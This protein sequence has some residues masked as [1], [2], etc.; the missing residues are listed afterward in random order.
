MVKI[1]IKDHLKLNVP[2]VFF[3]LEGVAS[4]IKLNTLSRHIIFFSELGI[5]IHSARTFIF[6]NHACLLSSIL[7]SMTQSDMEVP[8]YLFLTKMLYSTHVF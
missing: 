2:S 4:A 6:P 8:K 3:L 5:D 1:C 7:F